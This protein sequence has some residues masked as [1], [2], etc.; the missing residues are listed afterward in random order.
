MKKK[1]SID[2]DCANCAVKI[3]SA[4]AKLPGVQDCSV[5]FMTQKLSLTADDAS[6]GEVLKQA[7]RTAKRIEP[8]FE[9]QL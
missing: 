8:D 5:S 4:I 9:I 6:F 1:Y 2:V 7:V 3:E